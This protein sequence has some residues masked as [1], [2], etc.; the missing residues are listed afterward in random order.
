ME[1]YVGK[2]DGNISSGKCERLC[3]KKCVFL[4]F[5]HTTFVFL[6]PDDFNIFTHYLFKIAQSEAILKQYSTII[7]QTF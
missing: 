5:C 1:S 2:N 3:V 4:C 6:H 7:V